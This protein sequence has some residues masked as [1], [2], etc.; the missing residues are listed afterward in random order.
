MREPSAGRETEFRVLILAGQHHLAG[1]TRS[2]SGR[3]L[4]LGA[5]KRRIPRHPGGPVAHSLPLFI[6]QSSV[7]HLPRVLAL[8]LGSD[9]NTGIEDQ[10]HA[11]GSS[12]SLWNL[13]VPDGI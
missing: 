1:T 4:P 2:S 13:G 5:P 12:R 11:G 6:M 3:S 10:S 8:P 9:Q 7:E